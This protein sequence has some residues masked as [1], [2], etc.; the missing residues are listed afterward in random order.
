MGS[1]NDSLRVEHTVPERDIDVAQT[2]KTAP[3]LS[4]AS[5]SAREGASLKDRCHG[6]VAVDSAYKT[7]SYHVTII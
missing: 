1:A 7:A 2:H 4:I 6:D 3:L 5:D